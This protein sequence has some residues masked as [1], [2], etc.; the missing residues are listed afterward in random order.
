[1]VNFSEFVGTSFMNGSLYATFINGNTATVVSNTFAKSLKVQ[2]DKHK[3]NY[4]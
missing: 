4:Y 3:S 2:M 1:V